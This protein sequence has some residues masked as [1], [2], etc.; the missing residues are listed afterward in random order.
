MF[1]LSVKSDVKQLTRHLDKIQKKQVPFATARALTWTVKEMQ[2]DISRQIPDIFNTT[3]KWWLAQQPT[4]IKITPAKK[5]ELVA[6]VYCRA[7]FLH[8]QEYGGIKIPFR[9]RGLLVPSPLV[10]KY[11]RKAG[12]AIKVLNGK[13]ILRAGGTAGGDPV[14]HAP[15]GTRGVFR[16]KGKARLPIER[17]YAYTPNAHILPR[18]GFRRMAAHKARQRFAANFNKSLAMALK[19]A[20]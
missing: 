7:P 5:T 11:G 6:A 16:R 20:R 19:S 1:S 10:P 13:K 8:L 17:L 12:G 4:G 15:S 18:F 3:R 9:G 14:V 2:A